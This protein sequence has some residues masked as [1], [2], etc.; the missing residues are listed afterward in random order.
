MKL[1][2]VTAMMQALPASWLSF[3][4]THR[5]RGR[6]GAAGARPSCNDDENEEG[7]AERADKTCEGRKPS[8]V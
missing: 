6:C 5:N 2:S 8:D 4:S 7:G 1:P 3:P